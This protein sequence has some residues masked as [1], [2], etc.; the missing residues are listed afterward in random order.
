MTFNW[1]TGQEEYD[2]TV[3]DVLADMEEQQTEE[4]ET[5]SEMSEALFRMEQ[6]SLYKSLLEHS[7]FGANSASPH[8]QQAVESELREF[9][10]GRFKV[11]LGM[12]APVVQPA[13]ISPFTD[14]EIEALKL[15]AGRIT[16]K[17]E[18]LTPVPRIPQ[19]NP[20]PAQQVSVRPKPTVAQVQP[21]LMVKKTTTV[22]P[23]ATVPQSSK[24]QKQ[25]E[26]PVTGAKPRKPRQYIPK[27]D[28]GRIPVPSENERFLQAARQGAQGAMAA[29]GATVGGGG[30]MSMPAGSLAGLVS[31]YA[32]GSDRAEQD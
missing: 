2:E 16:K 10:S 5:L 21:V 25:T 23:A 11:L 22:S 27:D 13:Y 3:D 1:E 20:A 17:P 6:A 32:T 29:T 4:R 28:T 26:K 30:T 14:D 24:V 15:L 7:F 19:I 8:I 9:V 12:T 31:Q 18:V